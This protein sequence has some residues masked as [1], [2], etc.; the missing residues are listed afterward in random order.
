MLDETADP[1]IQE[2]TNCVPDVLDTHTL[3]PAK[4]RGVTAGAYPPEE[5]YDVGK[6]TITDPVDVAAPLAV[7]NRDK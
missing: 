7:P 5:L 3:A 6:V 4:S 1:F 2:I